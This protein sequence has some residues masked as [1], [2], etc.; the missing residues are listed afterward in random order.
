MMLIRPADALL[1]LPLAALFSIVLRMRRSVG[2]PRWWWCS[3]LAPTVA[4]SLVCLGL[5]K[6]AGI[7]AALITLGSLENRGLLILAAVSGTIEMGTLRSPAGSVAL[8]RV[9]LYISE[10]SAAIMLT[11]PLSGLFQLA[12]EGP[13]AVGIF[14]RCAGFALM[15]SVPVILG[16]LLDVL[17]DQVRKWLQRGTSSLLKSV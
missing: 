5:Q 8:V 7:P 6:K 13:D 12:P 16:A 10:I 11:Q 4:A 9:F 14:A 2:M 15:V 1:A 3:S 17:T